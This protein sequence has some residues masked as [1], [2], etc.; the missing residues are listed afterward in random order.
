MALRIF[1]LA[2]CFV[3]L[4]ACAPLDANIEDLLSPPRINQ[5]QT[6]VEQALSEHISLG[7]IQY[8]YPQDGDYRSPFVFSDMSGDGLMEAVVFYT[9]TGGDGGIR[10]KVLR[11]QA[12]GNWLLVDDRA[13]F[14]DRVQIVR[15]ARLLDPHT[16]NLIV[17]W[18]DSA[19]GQRRLDVFSCR[20]GRLQVLSQN[21]YTV[22][23]IDRFMHGSLEQIALVRQDQLGRHL[24]S[25][26][27]RTP[28]GR[29]A[30]VGEA[31]LSMDIYRVLNLTKG[32][33][34]PGISGIYVDAR[35]FDAQ[36]ATE[37]FEVS[38]DALFPLVADID[39]EVINAL[40]QQTIRPLDPALLSVDLRRDGRV[41]VPV[42]HEE[43]LPGLVTES[44]LDELRLTL[45]MQYD[46]AGVLEIAD[47][48]IV[49]QEAGYLFFF[50]ARWVDHVTVQRRSEINI[51]QFFEVNPLTNLPYNELL[52]IRV[53]SISDYRD[54][55]LEGYIRLAERGI[56]E[57]YAYIPNTQSPLALTLEEVRAS[58]ML[59]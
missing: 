1:C 9:L 46:Y 43:A 7:A 54:Q 28:D 31:V 33:M 21:Y 30:S 58:F 55:L 23:E 25:L 11:E 59:F 17:G 4:S 56:F 36:I 44:E 57:Y 8:Q 16:L 15:F 10:V 19:S 42:H 52:R 13:G 32:A 45:F 50:P 27:G 40:Y 22:F 20:D 6:Q 37:I 3:L 49:N 18:E 38:A 34:R 24:L 14:G 48:A 53:D 39:N 35:R 29:L 41:V 5:R 47:T 2:L 12:G 51:W 26:L